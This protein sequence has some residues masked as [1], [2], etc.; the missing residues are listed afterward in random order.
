MGTLTEIQKRVILDINLGGD[1]DKNAIDLGFVRNMFYFG[2]VNMLLEFFTI[3]GYNPVFRNDVNAEDLPG[4]EAVREYF[5]GDANEVTYAKLRK[6]LGDVGTGEWK[7]SSVGERYFGK[8]NQGWYPLCTATGYSDQNP[9]NRGLTMIWMYVLNLAIKLALFEDAKREDGCVAIEEL[10][11]RGLYMH[12]N[13]FEVVKESGYK[14]LG[15]RTRGGGMISDPSPYEPMGNATFFTIVQL[16]HK[17]FEPA[18]PSTT[19]PINAENG[20]K[21]EF[22]LVT[23]E[24][25]QEES[26][27]RKESNGGGEQAGSPKKA[28]SGEKSANGKQADSNETDNTDDSASVEEVDKQKDSASV[29]SKTQTSSTTMSISDASSMAKKLL[30]NKVSSQNVED[31]VAVVLAG[32]RDG[33]FGE[34]YDILAAKGGVDDMEVGGAEGGSKSDEEDGTK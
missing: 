17:Y 18:R 25:V 8:K 33:K 23:A 3:F 24:Q 2:N 1:Y 16:G 19:H 13:E 29:S 6:T 14:R 27:K 11:R 26:K 32:G 4:I 7:K 9:C 20:V 30:S 15:L 22:Q 12:N 10:K 28:K 5:L 21:L 31:M 34:L